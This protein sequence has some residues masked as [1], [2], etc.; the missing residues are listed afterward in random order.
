MAPEETALSEPPSRCR[1]A[2]MGD[3]LEIESAAKRLSAEERRRLILSLAASLREEGR[4]LPSPR[5]FT[6]AE[7][8]AWIEEDERDLAEY[9]GGA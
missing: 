7:I 6:S 9:R 1:L 8:E 4:P 2:L 3:F 5:R